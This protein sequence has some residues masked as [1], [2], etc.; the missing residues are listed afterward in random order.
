MHIGA[1]LVDGRD[2]RDAGGEDD[3][4]CEG[5]RAADSRGCAGGLHV[6][7]RCWPARSRLGGEGAHR[8]RYRGARASIGTGRCRCRA[9]T[10]RCGFLCYLRARWQ[11]P[12]EVHLENGTVTPEEIPRSP[13][14]DPE[15]GA[16]PSS[17]SSRDTCWSNAPSNEDRLTRPARR[18]RDAGGRGG[19]QFECPADFEFETL[20]DG[21]RRLRQVLCA[22]DYHPR[23][24]ALRVGARR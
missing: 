8:I 22:A 18:V 7:S 5:D 19:E 17:S 14:P 10:D 13:P 9:H 1:V 15:P 6:A 16:A 23:D 3:R 21:R 24:L 2:Q 11:C 12:V 20:P 4:R